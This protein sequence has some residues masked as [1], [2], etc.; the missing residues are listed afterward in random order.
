MAILR[1]GDAAVGGCIV[2][3]IILYLSLY[4]HQP[5]SSLPSHGDESV[6]VGGYGGNDYFEMQHWFWFC[7]IQEILSKGMARFIAVP[8]QIKSRCNNIATNK[9]TM[10][11]IKFGN[12]YA[13]WRTHLHLPNRSSVSKWT[14]GSRA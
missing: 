10:V 2:G 13:S 1:N 4:I 11:L 12:N 3:I 14:A 6:V 9:A 5:A 7:R 8:H